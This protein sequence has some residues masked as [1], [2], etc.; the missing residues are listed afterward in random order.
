MSEQDATPRRGRGRKPR[1]LS[2]VGD[3]PQSVL[4]KLSAE[5]YRWVRAT[6]DELK[7][8]VGSLVADAVSL[9]RETVER[10]DHGH[11]STP[12]TVE[13]PSTLWSRIKRWAEPR[14]CDTGY[15]TARDIVKEFGVA[16]G[17][18]LRAVNRLAKTSWPT[19]KL[20][21][22]H[23]TPN[24]RGHLQ[25][26]VTVVGSPADAENE[27]RLE[28]REYAQRTRDIQRQ[29]YIETKRSAAAAAEAA[30]DAE[31]QA[32]AVAA[33]RDLMR[34]ERELYVQQ[35]DLSI[36]RYMSTGMTKDEAYYAWKRDDD[37]Q[38][39]TKLDG[40][41]AAAKKK[42]AATDDW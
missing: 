7:V 32:A 33:S 5:D 10:G 40:V 1:D 22:V 13:S 14:L 41:R 29:H 39:Q 16:H 8:P 15:I 9:L 23:W 4:V 3:E 12:R 24:A 6:A 2:A 31:R 27:R 35:R 34:R 36:E 38:F 20:H 28:E 19:M 21:A 18:A 25:H 17:T 30:A 42:K 26:A 11:S 37:L